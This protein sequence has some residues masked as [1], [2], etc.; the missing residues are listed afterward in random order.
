MFYIPLLYS[1]TLAYSISCALAQ[2]APSPYLLKTS[3]KL[4]GP[5][6]PWQA[7]QVQIGSNLTAVDLYPG[8]DWG[9]R[10]FSSEMCS[11]STAECGAGGLFDQ[12]SSTTLDESALARPI[13]KLSACEASPSCLDCTEDSKS[14][15]ALARPKGAENSVRV[16]VSL[17]QVAACYAP[18]SADCTE[19]PKVAAVA[20][21]KVDEPRSFNEWLILVA[22]SGY[23]TGSERKN[24]ATV[25]ALQAD[26]AYQVEPTVLVDLIRS[27]LAADPLACEIRKGL[28][29]PNAEIAVGWEE[30]QGVLWFNG[31]V[32]L[33]EPCRTDVLARNHDDSLTGHFGVEKTLELLQ[34]KHYWPN[35]GND[36][37]AAPGMRQVVR[38]YCESCAI[39]K[40]SKAPRHKPYGELQP[41]STP[42]FKWTDLTMNFVTEISWSRDWNGS[43]YDSILVVVNRLSKMVHYVPMAKTVSAENLAEIF[44]R[45]VVRL[46]GLPESIVTDRGFVFTLKFYSSLCYALKVKQKLSTAFHPQTD[47]QTERQ[48]SSMEQYLRAFINYE[49]DD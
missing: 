28:A 44:V 31:K 16:A 6:G 33:P 9:S 15:S 17:A 4:Y 25:R 38:E 43:M 45:E 27:M 30:R 3:D 39:C 8:G 46:H 35:P 47:S 10:I 20:Q 36:S 29:T 24:S 14:E 49:Q 37:E 40:R 13:Q 34:R 12:S 1:F 42:E 22:G 32:Y 18:G 23:D 5:D 48:N 21:L 41:L 26:E 2:N 11:G 7:V 19:R